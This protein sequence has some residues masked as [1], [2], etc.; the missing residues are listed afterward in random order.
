MQD[1]VWNDERILP[2]D[3]MKY[4]TTPTAHVP[5]NEY[6]AQFWLNVGDKDDPKNRR[7]PSLPHDAYGLSG[8]QGQSVVIIPSHDAVIVRMGLT[9]D[10]TAWS[11]DEFMGLVLKALPKK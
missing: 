1:G 10:Y 9:E 11:Q 4:S 2:E 6:G 3:W 8:F 7:W 5:M